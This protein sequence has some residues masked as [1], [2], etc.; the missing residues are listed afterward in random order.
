MKFTCWKIT[1]LKSKALLSLHSME[2]QDLGRKTRK[3]NTLELLPDL[4]EF[5]KDQL[6]NN[7]RLAHSQSRHSPLITPNK[8]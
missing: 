4:T 5:V 3:Q 6:V 2:N 1:T 8:R 7:T